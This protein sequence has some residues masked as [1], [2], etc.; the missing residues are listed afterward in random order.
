M[1][2]MEIAPEVVREYKKIKRNLLWAFSEDKKK[3]FG[4]S[5]FMKLLASISIEKLNK[6]I[7][8]SKHNW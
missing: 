7:Y 4:Y 1:G 2:T 3:L 5:K 8:D 6:R